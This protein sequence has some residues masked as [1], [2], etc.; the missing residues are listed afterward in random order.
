MENKQ[1]R[2]IESSGGQIKELVANAVPENTKQNRQNTQL[3]YL[4][5]SNYK[6]RVDIQQQFSPR[7]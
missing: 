7:T 2:F 4:K 5:V 6:L 3:T 1:T